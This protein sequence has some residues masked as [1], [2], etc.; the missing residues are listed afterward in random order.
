MET[1]GSSTDNVQDPEAN[2]VPPNA[3]ADPEKRMRRE[4][5]D[6]PEARKRLVAHWT[7]AVRTDKKHWKSA[8]DQMRRDQDFCYGKQ[9]SDSRWEDDRYQANVTLRHVTQTVASLYAK[10]PKVKARRKTRM[11]STVWD[12]T[13]GSV[14]M[15]MQQ[16]QMAQPQ[17]GMPPAPV[18]PAMIQ[19]SM[20]LLQDAQQTVQYKEMM[21]KFGKTLELVYEYNVDEQAHP[22]KSMMKLMVRRA[23][24]TGVGYVKL[25][26]Q[27]VMQ[28]RPEIEA[29][30]A[31]ATQ[32]MATLERLSADFADG[33]ITDEN[34][35][36]IEELRLMLEGLQ[37]QPEMVVRE[38]LVFDYPNST[39]IIPDKRTLQL[40]EFLGADHVT[41]EYVLTPDEV[42]EIYNIDIG[43]GFRAYRPGTTDDPT[44]SPLSGEYDPQADAWSYDKEDPS[45]DSYKNAVVMVWET[46][47]RKDGLVYV[48]CDGYGDFLREPAPPEVWTERFW[49]WFPYVKNECDHPTKIFPPSDVGLMRDMQKEYN[50]LREG[51]REHR[52]A[53]RPAIAAAGGMLSEADI[54]KLINRPANAVLELDG[55]QPGQTVE[56]VLSALKMPGVDPNLYEINPIFEDIM[57]T[58]GTSEA[59]M[60]AA[61]GNTATETSIAE[62]ARATTTGSNVDELDEMLTALAR[63]GGQILLAEVSAEV[64]KEIIGPGAVWPELTR[65]E[66]AKEIHL[67]I[68]AG[69]TGKPNQAQEIQNFERLAP[70]LMQLPGVTPE[71]LAKEA[72]RRL[73][74]RLE[75]D[76]VYDQNMLSVQAM[77]QA[78]GQSQQTVAE[79]DPAAQGAEGA[80]NGPQP[81]PPAGA[82]SAG[83]P[84]TTAPQGVP[85]Q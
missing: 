4:E 56:Q 80:N 59:A 49:P 21:D 46:Y 44:V 70:I 84:Q 74:D 26:F 72:L 17:P 31:D 37:T 1:T 68:E 27:R 57:R 65:D 81:T 2:A 60:G 11:M 9:W 18:N 85:V 50:R 15:A 69:S 63:A 12:G 20:Q 58:V 40:R 71:M 10:N 52:I 64:V 8:F 35:K 14:M 75:L 36:E 19:Q 3:G 29:K 30:I 38:G 22:F 5:G 7:N 47:N 23:V 83:S 16:V 54:E 77:N 61:A 25:G 51:L 79:E 48:T 41:Q 53:N 24:T 78:A 82:S 67:E 66:L 28:P 34:A 42:K 55:L 33:E 13:M 32:K 45:S 43:D 73:D 76:E 6:I 39:S 62:S